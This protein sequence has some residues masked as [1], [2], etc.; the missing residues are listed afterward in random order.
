VQNSQL[1][2]QERVTETLGL[3]YDHH[4]PFRQYTT[5]RN[6]RHS[7]IHERLQSLN[8][9]FGELS[10]WERP[11][12]FAPKGVT[13]EYQSSFGKQ[14]WFEYSANEHRSTREQVALYDQ[15]SFS[16]YQVDG[17]DA[18]ECLQ[19]ICSANID[20]P[21][22]KTVYTHWLN[23][24][25]GIESDLTVTRISENQFWVISAAATTF[26]DL[27]WLAKNIPHDSHCFVSDITNSW[28]VF[29]IMGPNSRTLLEKVLRIDMSNEAFPFGSWQE[30][31]IGSAVGRAFRISFVGELGWELYIPVDQARHAFDY[32][33]QQGEAF[34]LVPAG[35]HA[36]DSCR[37]EKKFVHFGHDVA[38]KDTPLEAG[39]GFVCALEKPGGFIGREAILKQ[40]ENKSWMKK[41]LL[42][43]L[44][45]DPEA[46]LYHHEPIWQDGELVGHLTS[47]NYGHTLGGS[48]GL[49]YVTSKTNITKRTIEDS[50]FEIDVAGERIP[51]KASLSAMY[52]PKAERMRS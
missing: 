8:A 7:P 2:L 29:G 1:Y 44:L 28:A 18:C 6:L 37:I 33:W 12:W 34:N 19:H 32:L 26:K 15:S 21:P 13:P 40:K 50:K 27:N 51:A 11:N 4:Y 49:G 43:F 17:R 5:S 36:L 41:R 31:E 35:L 22:G 42:Q 9:C 25:G 46:M 52:D 30:V 20:V 48:V 45:E 23:S 24:R 39:L 47:G 38:N 16:K 3:L 10:G 14:N